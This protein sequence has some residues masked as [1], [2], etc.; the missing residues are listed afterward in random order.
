LKISLLPAVPCFALELLLKFRS[1]KQCESKV[2]N[3]AD[4]NSACFVLPCAPFVAKRYNRMGW[5]GSTLLTSLSMTKWN[6]YMIQ[7]QT[8]AYFIRLQIIEYRYFIKAAKPE[9][10]H[11]Y[12]LNNS[13]GPEHIRSRP[14]IILQF[15]FYFIFPAAHS[16]P[17]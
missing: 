14:L 6:F 10:Y 8:A 5:K 2:P 16:M 9:N 13:K 7:N 11:V 3:S 4:C 17:P 12:I 1:K 15:Y